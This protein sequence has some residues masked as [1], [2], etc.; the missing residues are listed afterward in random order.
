M[1][2]FRPAMWTICRQLNIVLLCPIH[3][4]KLGS[5]LSYCD[6][7]RIVCDRNNIEMRAVSQPIGNFFFL[8]FMK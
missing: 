5:V 3:F 7:S 8:I 1:E 4:D 2:T 6:N